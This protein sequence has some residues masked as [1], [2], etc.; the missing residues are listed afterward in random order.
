MLPLSPRRLTPLTL[1]LIICLPSAARAQ[2]KEQAAQQQVFCDPP[3]AV[4]LV[5]AQLSEAKAFTDTS[6]RIVVTTRA[7]DLLWPYERQTARDAFAE[8]FDLASAY[9]RENGDEVRR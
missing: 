7:A 3:R 1:V 8:A 2:G 5:R 9:F 6:K 4:A